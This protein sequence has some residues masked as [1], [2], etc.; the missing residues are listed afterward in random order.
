ML[1]GIPNPAHRIS[2]DENAHQPPGERAGVHDLAIG[3]K[4]VM[5]REEV[6]RAWRGWEVGEDEIWLKAWL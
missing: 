1:V 5:V 6:V 4:A 3:C 2:D